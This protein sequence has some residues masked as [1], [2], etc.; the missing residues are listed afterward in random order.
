MIFLNQCAFSPSLY[1]DW[2]PHA[3]GFKSLART[4][5]DEVGQALWRQ[6]LQPAHMSHRLQELIKELA[7]EWTDMQPR[8]SLQPHMPSGHCYRGIAIHLVVVRLC[9]A[10]NCLK[11]RTKQLASLAP[12]ATGG[13]KGGM[14]QYRLERNLLIGGGEERMGV[15]PVCVAQ[16]KSTKSPN[17]LLRTARM[18][19]LSRHSVTDPT[20]TV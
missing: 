5:H 3:A 11:K 4:C 19:Q 17:P 16:H 6:Q 20:A 7:A 10:V 1:S 9:S 12:G 13:F 2:S 18:S 15:L 8:A 14:P